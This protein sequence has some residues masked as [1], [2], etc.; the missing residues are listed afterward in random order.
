MTT[1]FFLRMMLYE[2]IM[3]SYSYY[4]YYSYQN[5]Y[6][7]NYFKNISYVCIK[8][9]DSPIEMLNFVLKISE[10]LLDIIYYF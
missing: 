8:D 2:I 1:R 7:T 6:N 9:S 10:N 5:S 3:T 4:S